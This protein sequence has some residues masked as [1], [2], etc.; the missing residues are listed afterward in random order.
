MGIRPFSFI[1]T[2]IREWSNFFQQT[3]V[4]PSTDSVS[5]E[6]L[7]DN[8]VTS[9][10]IAALNVTSAKLATDAVSSVKIQDNAITNGKLRDSAAASVIGCAAA[11]SGDPADIAAD[12]DGKLLIRRAGLLGFD[13][14]VAADIPAEFL[15]QTEGD[16]RYPLL[17]NTLNGSA[18][19]DPPNLLT[20]TGA[21][22]TVA[23]TGAALNDFAL[24]SFSLDLQGVT[25]TAYV[26]AA[27]T[28]TVR[29]QNDTA[30]TLD[31]ASGTLKV[32][33]FK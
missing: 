5:T 1:P 33:I 24:A 4:T 8:S 18:T 22:T 9:A 15:T 2:N 10:K 21:S 6:L 20:L 27:D 32:R 7:K 14:L 12:A 31:L 23:V 25:V 17:S 13:T 19:Y 28:V 26:S 11:S 3:Q 30:G 29:F 16:A